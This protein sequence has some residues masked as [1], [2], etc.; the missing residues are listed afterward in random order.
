MWD[1]AGEVRMNSLALYFSG[2]LHMD[3][4]RQADQLEPI[5]NKFVS[6]Q[7]VAWK[8]SKAIDDKDVWRERVWEIIAGSST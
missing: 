8:I 2:P 4:Q 5:Y 1:T 6:I 7:D 3:D